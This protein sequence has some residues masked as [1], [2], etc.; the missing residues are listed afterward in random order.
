MHS[1]N[2]FKNSFFY[3]SP[4]IVSSL[5]PIVTLPFFTREFTTTEFGILTLSQVYAIFMNGISNFGLI[6]GFERHFFETRDELKKIKLLYSIVLFVIVC[7]IL[8]LLFTFAI[9]NFVLINIFKVYG[10]KNILTLAFV[11]NAISSL[12]LYFLSYFKNSNNAKSFA[13]YSIDETLFSSIFS[14]IFVFYFKYNIY[15]FILGQLISAIL[16]FAFLII[17]FSRINPICFDLGSLKS[18]LKISL[19]LTPKVFLGILNNQLDKYFISI[20]STV[21]G[22]GIYNIAQKIANSAFTFMTAIQNIFSP[23]VYR[24]MFEME[25]IKAGKYIGL[26][27]T[28]FYYLSVFFALLVS[29]FSEELIYILYPTNYYSAID[30]TSVFTIL[31]VSYFFSKHPQIIYSK[32]TWLSSFLFVISLILNFVIGIPFTKLWGPIGAAWGSVFSGITWGAIYFYVSQ[33]CFYIEWEK[34][35]LII[36]S[37]VF[38]F[39]TISL[40]LSRT[41]Q[42]DYIYKLMLKIF[43]L[44]TFLYIGY[45]YKIIRLSLYMKYITSLSIKFRLSKVIKK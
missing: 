30:I 25:S 12:K 20:L 16:V 17:R 2:V 1:N 4:I 29:L 24:L 36:I 23:R 13:L 43:F 18:A 9:E 21:G 37:F 15:G 22:V 35:K 10:Y 32:K 3:I 40:L 28:P 26:Y 38:I 41:Y 39:S 34:K 31:Y 7:S 11:A 14:L 44:L 19:P 6:T 5:V 33:K 45:Y 8:F 42:I 27:L